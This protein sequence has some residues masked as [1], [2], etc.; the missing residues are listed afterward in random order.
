MIAT[1]KLALSAAAALLV[2][3]FVP[4]P[5]VTLA[6]Y[7][8]VIAWCAAVYFLGARITQRVEGPGWLSGAAGEA[9]SWLRK[10][11]RRE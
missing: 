7:A 2:A 1:R 5:G 11:T 8:L 4:I 6:V 9:M 10:R 3:M